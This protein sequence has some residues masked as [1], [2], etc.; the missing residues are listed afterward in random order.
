MD[1]VLNPFA[2]GRSYMHNI[3]L[4]FHEAGHIIFMPFGRFM[5]I[6]GGSLFQ[7]IMPLIVMFSFLIKNRNPFGASVGLWWTGQS[8]M[9]LAPYIDDAIDQKLILLGGRTGADAPGN[10]DWGNIFIELGNLERHRE[11]ATY[12]DSGGTFLMLLALAW[13]GF[14]LY[15]QFN[16]LS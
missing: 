13:G 9:D 7:L 2:I 8:L 6:L 11:I 14:M 12:A 3:N 4:I 16:S 5:T 10:H 15:K 1:F